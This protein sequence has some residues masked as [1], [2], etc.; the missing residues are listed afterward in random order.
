MPQFDGPFKIL[1]VNRTTS[2]VKLHLPPH[3]KVHPIFHTS[4]IL[5]Y[6]ENNA[7]MFPGQ[8][9]AKPKPIINKSGKSKYFVHDIINKR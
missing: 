2:S 3:S 7:Q 5:P 4:L 8:E 6:K 1:A 9:F